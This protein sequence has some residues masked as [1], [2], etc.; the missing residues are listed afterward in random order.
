VMYVAETPLLSG[1][2]FSTQGGPGQFLDVDSLQVLKGPQGTLFGRNA[3][4]GAILLAPRRPREE[5]GGNV[6]IQVGNYS[7]REVEGV[8]NVPVVDKVLLARGAFQIVDRD[9][10]TR[11]LEGPDLDDKRY[12]TGRLGI[13][14]RPTERV[15]NYF[16]GF[17]TAQRNRGTGFVIEAVNPALGFGQLQPLVDDQRARGPRAVRGD[18]D[19]HDILHTFGAVNILSI[20]LSDNARLRNITSYSVLRHSQRYNYDGLGKLPG[21]NEISTF[22]NGREQYQDNTRQE[23]EELQLQ[24]TAAEGA[25]KHVSGV[26]LER[27][28]P[29]GANQILSVGRGLGVLQRDRQYGV[30][31]SSKAVYGQLSYDLGHATPL[32]TGIEVTGGLRYTWDNTQ[33]FQD[34]GVVRVAQPNVERCGSNP[35]L[36]RPNCLVTASLQSRAATWLLGVSYRPAADT[37][38]YSKL[39]TGYKAGGVNAAAVNLDSLTYKPEFARALELGLKSDF[40]LGKVPVRFNA[41]VYTTDYTD[42]QRGASDANP[43]INAFGAKTVNAASARISGFEAEVALRPRHGLELSANYSYTDAKYKNFSVP[44]I[45]QVDCSGSLV[46]SL[47]PGAAPNADLSCIPFPFVAKNQYSVSIRQLVQLASGAGEATFG[48]TYSHQSEQYTAWT[49]VPGVEPGSVLGPVG[50]L[51]IALDWRP[52]SRSPWNVHLFATNALNK[53]YRIGNSGVY[54]ALGFQNSVYGEPR[55]VGIRLK[56]AF[57]SVS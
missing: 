51:T 57:G 41:D 5:F 27:I 53:T 16:M 12:W 19:P 23:T 48:A 20:E 18:S 45:A 32:L 3:T 10:F 8:V 37:L 28:R 7:D 15:D 35:S 49:S 54:N 4:G 43:A 38:L 29:D 31:R 47:V 17:N 42:I 50:L 46:G 40:R 26:Y 21:I 52:S 30:S 6:Q 39:S 13:T 56:Y 55:T 24:G 36:T 2:T 14:F 33:G 34:D 9:G 44:T 22:V 1:F 25:L 11:N